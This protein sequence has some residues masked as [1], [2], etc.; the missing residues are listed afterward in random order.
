MSKKSKS[1]GVLLDKISPPEGLLLLILA[2]LI[3]ASTGLAA[4]FF[5][6]S[7]C[8]D[9]EPIL[10]YNSISVPPSWSLEFCGSACGRSSVGRA[11]YCLVCP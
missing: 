3:G 9:S 10:R 4:V 8:S 1:Y 7:Y 11:A 6:S 5:H 2:M